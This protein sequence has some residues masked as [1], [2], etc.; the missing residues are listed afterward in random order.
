MKS[1]KVVVKMAVK[2]K[3]ACSNQPLLPDNKGPN[4][5][6]QPFICKQWTNSSYN[7]LFNTIKDRT[8][9]ALW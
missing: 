7:L 3:M 9:R 4:D 1:I 6:Q 8:E 2:K 5:Q